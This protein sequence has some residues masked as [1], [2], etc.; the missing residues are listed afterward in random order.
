M[1][2]GEKSNEVEMWDAV[3]NHR[4]DGLVL[5]LEEAREG[6]LGTDRLEGEESSVEHRTEGYQMLTGKK[7][8]RTFRVEVPPTTAIITVSNHTCSACTYELPFRILYVMQDSASSMCTINTASVD[9]MCKIG[10]HMQTHNGHTN[11]RMGSS[12]DD[13]KLVIEHQG[14]YGYK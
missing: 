10:P 1:L 7:S 9:T 4:L 11:S 13:Y 3:S 5:R 2:T 14:L 6:R 8:S 12:F